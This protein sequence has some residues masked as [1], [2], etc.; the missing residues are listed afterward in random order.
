M[1]GKES[2]EE[3]LTDPALKK[4]NGRWGAGTPQGVLLSTEEKRGSKECF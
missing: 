3:V 4:A 2:R 1:G